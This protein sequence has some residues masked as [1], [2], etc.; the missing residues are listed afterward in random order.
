MFISYKIEKYAVAHAAANIQYTLPRVFQVCNLGPISILY[1]VYFRIKA[2]Q[3]I[4][5]RIC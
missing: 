3:H 4:V 2:Q 5:T 1:V